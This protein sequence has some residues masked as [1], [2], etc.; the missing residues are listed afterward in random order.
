MFLTEDP[1]VSNPSIPGPEGP[2]A[3]LDV[4]GTLAEIGRDIASSTRRAEVVGQQL[5]V[6]LQLADL[7]EPPA[8]GHVARELCD[9]LA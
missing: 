2:D 7:A 5:A 9:A 8:A 6:A 4:I 1:P 3:L